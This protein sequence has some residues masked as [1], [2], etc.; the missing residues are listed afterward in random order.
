MFVCSYF[1]APFTR[2]GNRKPV[3]VE[4]RCPV[5]HFLGVVC[6]IGKR[7]P[8]LPVGTN[9]ITTYATILSIQDYLKGN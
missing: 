6:K 2:D 5:F 1:P 8:S 9:D 4:N 3:H 7:F